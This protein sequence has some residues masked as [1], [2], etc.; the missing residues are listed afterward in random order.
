MHIVLDLQACQSP[1]G[2]RRGIGRYSLALAKA[3][4]AK[5]RGHTITIFLNET[6][7]DSIEFLRSEF[8]SLLPQDRIVTWVALAPT[9]SI[10]QEN[11]FR[12][13]ASEALRLQAI[14]KLRPDV[15]HTASLFDGWGDN[16]ISTIP[17]TQSY[18]EAVTCYDL[19]PL[20]HEKTYLCDV[21]VKSW[22]MEKAKNLCR[23][24]VLL[25][26]SR[27]SCCEATELLG[28]SSE[29][30]AN[31]SGAV[32]DI[33]MPLKNAE[34]FRPA[35]VE[36]YGLQRPFIMY[37]GGFDARKNIGTLIRAFALLPH[38][39]R[40][41]HQLVVVGGAP[42]PELEVLSA[43]AKDVGLDTDEVVFTGYVSD[44]D[45][46]RFYNLCA[47]Y[48]FPSLQE[49]FGLPALEAMSC[50]AIVIGS[51]TSS[52]PEVIGR[53]DALFDPQS[54]SAIT[55][56]MT[57]GLTDQGFRDSLRE[58]GRKQ[59]QKFSWSESA[60]RA[61][62][63]FETAVQQ[64]RSGIS[65]FIDKPATRRRAIAYL[66]AP[67]VPG[68]S[69][70]EG[71]GVIFA[72]K[73][74]LGVRPKHSLKRFI[75]D[76]NRFD[77]VTIELANVPYCADT[78]IFATT[79]V[80]DIVLCDN[81]FGR[82]LETLAHRSEGHKLVVSLLYR[83]SGYGALRLAIDAGF[84]ATVLDS[85]V[86]PQ[87][88]TTLGQSQVILS[89]V[90]DDKIVDET[91]AWRDNIHHVVMKLAELEH[92]FTILERDWCAVAQA[93]SSNMTTSTDSL[94]QWFV[95]ISNLFVNDAGTGIQRVV[96][97]VLD[98]LISKPPSGYRVEPIFL[99]KDG[100]FRYARSYCQMRYFNGEMLPPDEPVEFSSTD[101]YLGLDLTAHLIPLHIKIFRKMRNRGVKQ[102][103]VV[104]DLLPLLRP[105]CFDPPGLPLFR[106]WYESVAEVADGVMC[107]SRAVADEFEMWLQQARP[108]RLRPLGIGWFHLG[109]D[110]AVATTTPGSGGVLAA[111]LPDLGE[112]P[113][114]LMVGTIEPR[115]GHAQS[116]AAFDKLWAQGVQ[117]NLLVIGKPGWLVDDLLQR[118]RS[119]PQRG[120]QLFWLEKAGDD[121]LLA[122][123]G[124]ASALLM[125]SEGEGFG[126]PLIE[127]AHH[128]VPLLARDL[129]VFREIAG[130]HAAYF[131]GY[132]PDDLADALLEWLELN[133]RGEA[134]QSSGMPWM[135]WA[136]A[137][138]Q[139]VD[140]VRR[141]NWVH[142][143]MPS[144][145][146][147]FGV[148]DYRFLTQV[149]H[150]AR[151]RM[152][153][154]GRAGFLLYGPNV[155]MKASRYRV[156]IYGGGNGSA[157]M[158]ICSSFA[159]NVHIRRDFNVLHNELETL[160]VE[161]ELSLELDVSD[162]QTRIFVP[163]DS[164][165]W[166]SR[167]EIN[168]MVTA[169][170]D[171]KTELTA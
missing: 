123:Y 50:G 75:Q 170:R 105:D 88:L 58:H 133:A 81:T 127:A 89:K 13:R 32:D 147:R 60:K 52:L 53:E 25:G 57:K 119:H 93:L 61:I 104:Y 90:A 165:L 44:V 107:I 143:W 29:R 34:A 28:I 54:K 128:G 59:C 8:D 114:F 112:R 37:A 82:V 70:G 4:A 164:N 158:D 48:V 138:A 55:E 150:L 95:D 39:L 131:S 126:L 45:L 168:P 33:F 156:G 6:M 66:P 69:S 98:E 167:I 118:F 26:I 171:F 124:R 117:V 121:L 9:A 14:Q 20:A 162:L 68:I 10:N 100:V 56:M 145:S 17:G 86:K 103:F 42:D 87:G 47:L 169:Q 154:T 19:I 35:L 106:S 141:E 91:L 130:E 46:V 111:S 160:L 12:R 40:R 116:L 79:G 136:Q 161:V 11:M 120:K 135:T 110:L 21:R 122:A 149:G 134:P 84:S 23:A 146:H 153:T 157:W 22:Y 77:R 80:V 49:G 92:D 129:P 18:L 96:R 31:I 24:D 142:S 15:V 67:R 30:M 2:R 83:G 62:T 108:R 137:A 73:D 166:I 36:L 64:R 102:Y 163:A 113:T 76:R 152:T 99:A 85:L 101:I 72:N 3:M 94:S 155:P 1:E 148:F 16:V 5:P 63:A 144:P 97:H 140:V 74:C 132:E 159:N 65:G 51:N 71:G 109:A 115:K 27:F 41:E 7:G 43:L 78:L 151:G 38:E 125:A 139:L